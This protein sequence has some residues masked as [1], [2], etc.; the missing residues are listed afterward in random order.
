MQLTYNM[1]STTTTKRILLKISAL[2]LILFAGIMRMSYATD[3]YSVIEIGFRQAAEGMLYY[4][5]RA[6]VA[7]GYYI[8]S[9]CGMSPETIY[10]VSYVLALI[11]LVA[12]VYLLETMTRPIIRD[13]NI[14]IL[15]CLACI[16]NPFYVEY[17]M[18]IEKFG[19]ALAVLFAIL[20]VYHLAKFYATG[21]YRYALAGALCALLIMLTYQ[22][23]IA[24]YAILSVPFAYYYAVAE[25]GRPASEETYTVLKETS[26]SSEETPA[27]FARA[28]SLR[29]YL[30][31]LIAIGVTFLAA[32][33]SY[34][35]I[36]DYVIRANRET[37]DMAVGGVIGFFIH[38]LFQ[39]V[40]VLRWTYGVLPHDLLTV[41]A[42]I[43][44]VLIL[45]SLV[46]VPGRRLYILHLI[47]TVV[48]IAVFPAAP[49]FGGS[50][51]DMRVFYPLASVIGIL[52][53]N[54]NLLQSEG[55]ESA[56]SCLSKESVADQAAH[57]SR[58]TYA[59][60][61]RRI[62]VY[63]QLAVLVVLLT[64]TCIGFYRIYHDKYLCN[65][66]DRLRCEHIGTHIAAYE[67]ETGNKIRYIGFYSDAHSQQ[68][69]YPDL[70]HEGDLNTS[71][72][73]QGWSDLSAINYY[74]GTNYQ[75]AEWN[76]TYEDYFASHDWGQLNDEQMV[77]DGESLYY[78]IY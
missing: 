2:I 15:T 6:T 76:P 9:L 68:E 18:F 19:F 11:I 52:V 39:E 43:L 54:L 23:V 71:S 49:M 4:N 75:R 3:T 55:Q 66:A 78:G 61:S 32:A 47:M 14:R 16:V 69:Q 62:T 31:N 48:A 5:G 35:L 1:Q 60:V 17:M 29:L 73:L 12:A 38:I 58:A 74:L 21:R 27:A 41:L 51:F 36:Y 70:Y 24:L 50:G 72:F 65:Y 45:V 30:R 64:S 26:A 28:R 10:T 37:T 56:E 42:A 8:F 44:G 57:I 63:A 46:R 22:G 13:E 59:N 77:F 33:V 25:K 40:H 67:A 34:I 53:I 20:G 7:L